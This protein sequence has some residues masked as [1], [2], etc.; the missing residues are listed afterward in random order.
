MHLAK[1]LASLHERIMD[2][3]HQLRN[4]CQLEWPTFRNPRELG[5]IVV[6]PQTSNGP[7]FAALNAKFSQGGGD[8]ITLGKCV[9][10]RHH[11]DYVSELRKYTS[12]CINIVLYIR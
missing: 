4:Y 7:G 9:W 11:E 12:S 8:S 1:L 6:L 3:G 10:D 5:S 2:Q